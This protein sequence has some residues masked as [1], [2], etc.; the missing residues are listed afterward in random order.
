MTQNSPA[1]SVSPLFKADSATIAFYR[2]DRKV[3]VVYAGWEDPK[4]VKEGEVFEV[5]GVRRGST[6]ASCRKGKGS[7]GGREGERDA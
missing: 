7:A 3:R 4:V 5:R 1:S 2:H 6:G